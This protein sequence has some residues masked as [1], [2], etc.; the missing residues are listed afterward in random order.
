[1][2]GPDGTLVASRVE[3]LERRQL[4]AGGT[5]DASF[6]DDGTATVD[7]F[8]VSLSAVASKVDGQGRTVTVGGTSDGKWAVARFTTDGK[9]DPTFGPNLDGKILVSF[10]GDLDRAR[11]LAFQSDGKIVVVGH[12]DHLRKFAAVRLTTAGKLDTTFDGDGKKSWDMGGS[13]NT[14]ESVAVQ[15]DGKIVV[16]GRR[17]SGGNDDFAVARLNANGSFDSSF[18]G[19]GRRSVGLG[20]NEVTT[21]VAV[22]SDGKILVTGQSSNAAQAGGTATKS[23]IAAI[24]LNKNGSLDSTFDGDGQARY[25]LGQM[26]QTSGMVVQGNKVV[27][28]GTFNGGSGSADLVMAR[29]GGDGKLDTTFGGSGTGWQTTDL[30]GKDVAYGALKPTNG[31]ILVSALSNSGTAFVKFTADGALDTAFGSGGIARPGGPFGAG[32]ISAYGERFVM[33]GGDKFRTSRFLDVQANVVSIGT[34]VAGATETGEPTRAFVV[35]RPNRLPYA[36]QVYFDFKGTATVPINNRPTRASGEDYGVTYASPPAV[37]GLTHWQTTIPANETFATVVLTIRDDAL[38]EPTETIIPTLVPDA[39]Y[40][41]GLASTTFTVADNDS[42]GQTKTLRASADAFVKSGSSAG[43][44]FGNSTELQ[45]KNVTGYSGDSRVSYL[46]F[47]LASLSSIGTA[48]LRVYGKLNNPNQ[49]NVLTELRS[50]G[51]TNWSET[52]INWNNR[53]AVRDEVI[54][55]VTVSDTAARWYE[56]DVAAYLRAEKAAGHNTVTLALTN[57]N[58]SDPY[59]AFNSDEAAANRPELVVTS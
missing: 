7:S 14:A 37:T 56:F 31:G 32:K 52:G 49:T 36:T 58:G 4:F 1:M 10:A 28:T 16:A 23:G 47:D 55:S 22:L 38:I 8:G 53:P 13:S 19:D 30:G 21:G 48:R 18:D 39:G 35:T 29:L 25:Y 15:N 6:S 27:I 42:P 51:I 24:R 57:P 34:F 54:G 50:S 43:T 3:I 26:V 20:D 9:L 59:A 40:Q 11:D 41:I 5:P 45:V 33:A 44:N 46:K 2:R 17:Y 12:S